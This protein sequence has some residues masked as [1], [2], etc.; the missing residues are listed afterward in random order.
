MIEKDPLLPRNDGMSAP[1]SSPRHAIRGAAALLVGAVAAAYA[2]SLGGPFVYDDVQAIAENPSLRKLWP[3]TDVLFPDLVGGLTVSG[4]PLLNLSFA[5]NYAVSGEAVWSYHALNVIIHAGAALLLFGCAR[6]TLE[7]FAPARALPVAFALALLWALHPLHTESVT[8]IVQ[9][10][11]SLMGFSYLLAFYCFVRGWQAGAVLACAASMATKEVAVTLPVLLLLYDRTFGA[12]S[13]AAAWRARRGFYLALAASWVL[14]AVLV[15]STGGDRG[16]T[17]GFAGIGAWC[18]HAATQFEAVARYVGLGVWP[19]PLVFDYG[20]FAVQHTR[21]AIGYA[22]VVV[23]L[24]LAAMVSLWRWPAAGFC[25]AWFFVILAPASLTPSKIQ[26]IVE[27]RTYLSLAGLIALFVLGLEACLGRRAI[28]VAVAT[29]LA[30]GA[31]TWRRN[32]DYRTDETLWRDTIAKRPA[33]ALAHGNLAATLGKEG[34]LDEAI[35][36]AAQAAK[37]RPDEAMHH[38]NLG[39]ALAHA[40]HFPE[41]VRAYAEAV[42]LAPDEPAMHN[43]LAAALGRVGEPDAAL[44][45]AATAV[46]LAPHDAGFRFNHGAALARVGHWEEAIAAYEIALQLHPDYVDAHVNLASALVHEQRF[47]AALSHYRDA[48]RLNPQ[49]PEIGVSYAGTLLFTGQADAARTEFARVLQAHPESVEAR[50]GLGDALATLGQTAEAVTA[51]EAVIAR[52]PNYAAARYK[53]GNALIQLNR[54][55]DAVAQYRVALQLQPDDAEAHHN[56]GVA[57]ARL[58]RYAEARTELET[59]LRLR[60]DYPAARQ[61]LEQVQILAR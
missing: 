56:L 9:R 19:Q 39:L 15:A 13:F 36:H 14:L 10:A 21:E 60:P 45:H 6:R 61:H 48:L 3:L 18:A 7:R 54:P 23:P 44:A 28:A 16:G 4:R 40:D 22:L 53:L 32:Q 55:A 27:H 11:E 26:V 51:F 49:A 25:G 42:R 58:E 24:L 50:F 52:A 30:C 38:Y 5:L 34:R 17:M 47:T 12:G 33:N 1:P 2:N 8:Y 43:N 41:A 29:A 46:R 59:A 35:W 31:M 37:L 57:Y 20:L